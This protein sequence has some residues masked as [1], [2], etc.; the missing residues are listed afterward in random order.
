[1]SD[2]SIYKVPLVK[3]RTMPVMIGP[4]PLGAIALA[5]SPLLVSVFTHGSLWPL[6]ALPGTL[7]VAWW[8]CRDDVY[9]FNVLLAAMSIKR[10]PTKRQWGENRYVPR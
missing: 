7:F 6:G 3:S 2:T 1:M 5:L 8:M 9:I 4:F 10:S